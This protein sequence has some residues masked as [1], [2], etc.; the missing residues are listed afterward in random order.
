MVLCSTQFLN[1]VNLSSVSIALPDI[2]GDLPLRGV[3]GHHGGADER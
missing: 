2:A 3:E 1:I